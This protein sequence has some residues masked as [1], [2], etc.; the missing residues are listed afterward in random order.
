[1]RITN[2][3]CSLLVVT[4]L[5]SGCAQPQKPIYY[6]GSY[7][8]QLYSHF[9]GENSPQEEIA[10]LEEDA[11]KAAAEGYALPPGFAAHLGL[12]YGETGQLDKM[13][14]S[15]ETE[16]QRFPESSSYMDFL[17]KKFKP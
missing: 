8:G 11:N 3:A 13:A 14:T 4:L 16:K 15:L 7:Q 9:K 1:M 5:L 10:T 17:L 12:L 2:K 6:W